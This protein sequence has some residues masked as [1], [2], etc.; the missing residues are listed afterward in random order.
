MKAFRR[1]ILSGLAGLALLTHAGPAPA[2]VNPGSAT[3]TVI[4]GIPNLPAPVDVFVDGSK[5][6]D[7]DFADQEGPLV[8]PADDYFIEVKLLGT[9][10]LSTTATLQAGRD[11][12]AI[13]HLVPHADGIT[14]SLFENDTRLFRRGSTL[15]VRHTADA[16]EVNI[17]LLA[18]RRNI[19]IGTFGPLKNGGQVGPVNLPPARYTAVVRDAATNTVVA[20]VAVS[21]APRTRQIV[22]AV[23]SLSNGTFTVIVQEIPFSQV[24]LLGNR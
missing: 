7:F 15:T 4:H 2:I 1:I 19:R 13:A 10:V 24:I 8:L 23:G 22:Y 3:L 12:T 21:L 20:P 5:L 9:T 16:P 17:D 6:F 18:T 11:Y 14:L